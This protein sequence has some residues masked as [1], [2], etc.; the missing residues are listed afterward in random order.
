MTTKEI[1]THDNKYLTFDKELLEEFKKAHEKAVKNKEITIIFYDN[2][3]DTSYA[4]YI[5]EYLEPILK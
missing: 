3:F 1:L 2:L 4:K 5:I